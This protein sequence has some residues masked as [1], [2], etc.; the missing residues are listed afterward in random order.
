MNPQKFLVDPLKEGHPEAFTE[1]QTIPSGWNVSE[2]YTTE[3]FCVWDRSTQDVRTSSA[4]VIPGGKI[5]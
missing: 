4:P 5:A 1:P 2:M 3:T